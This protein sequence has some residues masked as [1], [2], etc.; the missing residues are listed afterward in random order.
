MVEESL[1]VLRAREV[2]KWRTG[3]DDS[4]FFCSVVGRLDCSTA[5]LKARERV[6]SSAERREMSWMR[7]SDV[8]W[9]DGG[10]FNVRPACCR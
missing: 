1:T 6:I 2:L 7:V 8:S 5:V 10:R 3:A 4:A 9:L